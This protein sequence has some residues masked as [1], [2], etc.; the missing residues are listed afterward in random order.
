MKHIRLLILL[1]VSNASMAQALEDPIDGFDDGD[2]AT[3]FVS[4]FQ[5]RNDAAAGLAAMMS[6]FLESQ[7]Q[8]IPELSVI[9]VYEA[10]SVHDMSAELYLESCP[11]GQAIGCAFVDAF[12]H[13]DDA[14]ADYAALRGANAKADIEPV[15]WSF[16][17]A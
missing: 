4:P 17:C 16:V 10:P 14:G 6:A 3:V 1:L 2:T 11:P 12:G 8:S 15:L 5:P 7:L 9:P 13:A